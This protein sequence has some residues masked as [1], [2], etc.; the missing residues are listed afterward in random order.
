MATPR[1]LH[2]SRAKSQDSVQMLS[3]DRPKTLTGERPSWAACPRSESLR[4]NMT[5]TV[6]EAV[7][8]QYVRETIREPL[9]RRLYAI[10]VGSPKHYDGAGPSALQLADPLGV[11][12]E[13][14]AAVAWAG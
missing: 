10:S 9:N 8:Y 5:G 12:T 11:L 7:G 14:N 13:G 3:M 1:P 6:P 4:N 2:I